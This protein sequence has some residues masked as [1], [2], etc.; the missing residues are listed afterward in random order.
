MTHQLI[1]RSWKV[2]TKRH[3]GVYRSLNLSCQGGNPLELQSGPPIAPRR[4]ENPAIE[5]ADAFSR[6]HLDDMWHTE[7][8]EY[9]LLATTGLFELDPDISEISRWKICDNRQRRQIAN[10]GGCNFVIDSMLSL[11]KSAAAFALRLSCVLAAAV[12]PC[13]LYQ[14]C[15]VELVASYNCRATCLRH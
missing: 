8:L 5:H 4:F 6:K 1:E 2:S 9:V 11:A 13:T 15:S 10:T 12:C 3:L 7:G 14:N